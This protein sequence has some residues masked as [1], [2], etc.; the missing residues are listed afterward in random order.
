MIPAAQQAGIRKIIVTHPRLQRATQAQM[1]SMA[2]QGAILEC[3]YSDLDQCAGMIKSI[4]AEHFIISSD[5]GQVGRPV[6]TDGMKTF[7]VHLRSQ[8]ITQAQID[9]VSRTN[10]ALLLGLK[11]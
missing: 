5:L 2:K 11:P 6:H 9:L 7:I 3:I 10:P 4:G 8:G 1:E